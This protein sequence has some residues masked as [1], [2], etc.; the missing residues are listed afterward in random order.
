MTIDLQSFCSTE[1]W[2]PQLH[3]PFNRGGY[4]WATNGHIM[5]RVPEIDGLPDNGGNANVEVVWSN[6]FKPDGFVAAPSASTLPHTPTVKGNCEACDGRGY[7]HECSHCNH[8]CEECDGSGQTDIK[9]DSLSS[10]SIRGLSFR[11]DY[12]RKIFALP[13]L[14]CS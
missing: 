4:T 9:S 6:Q 8:D 11:L 13:H 7:E 5:L 2:R 14:R 1:T 3:K 10:V 12:I